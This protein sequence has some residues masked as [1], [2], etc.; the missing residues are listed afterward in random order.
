MR[1]RG[2]TSCSCSIAL[3]SSPGV[4]GRLGLGGGMNADEETEVGEED[5]D[6]D[7]RNE[8]SRF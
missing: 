4:I 5:G 1:N 7:K 6:P 8:E 3:W 2:S